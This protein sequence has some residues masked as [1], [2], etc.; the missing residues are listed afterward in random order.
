MR[1]L[2]LADVKL[3]VLIGAVMLGVVLPQKMQ[4]RCAAE[5]SEQYMCQQTER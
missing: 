3:A 2:D 4:E 1:Q 5:T